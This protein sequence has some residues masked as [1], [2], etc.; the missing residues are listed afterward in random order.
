[1][2]QPPTVAHR[3]RPPPRLGDRTRKLGP[4]LEL[5]DAR[6]KRA[7]PD[8]GAVRRPSVRANME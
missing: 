8:R 1:M 7:I 4:L 6:S 3:I 2:S 5:Q